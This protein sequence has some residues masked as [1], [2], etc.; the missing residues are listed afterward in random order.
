[1]QNKW[2][3]LVVDDDFTSMK[4]VSALLKEDGYEVYATDDAFEAVE[5]FKAYGSDI[6]LAD[7]KMPEVDGIELFHLIHELDAD[8]PYI[9]MTAFGT[10]NSAV[11]AV[12]LG[13]ADYLIK[14]L[15]YD[16]LMLT[17]N[18]VMQNRELNMELEAFKHMERERG[19]NLG[20]VG[21]HPDI[22]NIFKMIDIIAPT[23]APVLVYGE[24][25]T[26]KEL[27]ARAIHKASLRA[28][29]PMICLNS[30]ALNDNL[31]EAELFGYVKG[32]FTNATSTKIGRLKLADGGTLFLDEISQMSLILQAKLLRF[33]QEG[34]FEPV[35]SNN[36]KKV[37]VRVVAA[38]N[39]NLYEA[40][41][42]KQFLS[43]LLYRLDVI[44][45]KVPPLRER[46][47]DIALLAEHFINMYAAKYRKKVLGLDGAALEA[48]AGYD[49]PGNVRQ[50]E[51]YIMRSVIVCK[52]KY[53]GLNDLPE[54]F[55]DGLAGAVVDNVP[56]AG[57]LVKN[58]SIKGLKL[59]DM[60]SELIVKM[61][62]Y[63]NG[64]KSK[65]AEMLGISRRALYTKMKRFG[66][67]CQHELDA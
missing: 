4:M 56:T 11:E 64:N 24:T 5:Y 33:L 29:K 57:G 55:R 61:I 31:L 21:R 45:L 59:K 18:K 38:T 50:L 36:T 48:L 30:A 35:G 3:I 46:R 16:E 17:L 39:K 53:I 42:N 34:T 58:M 23:D 51:N 49:W 2:R 25:G 54:Q 52:N 67:N 6:V 19:G 10:I 20:F 28:E 9:I 22:T 44:S 8:T 32:A 41:E 47:E 26:G 43:D 13:V 60:E 7:M 62:D 65:A 1:M 63:C 66:I 12:K 27:I 40:I 14:P 15:N 37:D